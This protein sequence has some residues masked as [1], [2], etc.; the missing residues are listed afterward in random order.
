MCN[1]DISRGD[2][3]SHRMGPGPYE[4]RAPGVV[5]QERLSRCSSEVRAK[6]I[7]KR[8]FVRRMVLEPLFIKEYRTRSSH[9]DSH[10]WPG[11]PCS[12]WS[13]YVWLGLYVVIGRLKSTFFELA[14]QDVFFLIV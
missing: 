11:T 1:S 13:V 12:N 10:D 7:Y 14:N 6:Q 8:E 9:I 3:C 4:S 2:C 5:Y